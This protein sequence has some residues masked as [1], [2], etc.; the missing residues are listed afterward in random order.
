MDSNL[1]VS[2]E[3]VIMLHNLSIPLA[4]EAPILLEVA[5]SMFQT[6]GHACPGDTY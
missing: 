5:V 1:L 3:D 2:C 6:W 4:Y